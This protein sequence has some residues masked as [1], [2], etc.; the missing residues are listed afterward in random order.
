MWAWLERP[1]AFAAARDTF[2]LA[3][4]LTVAAY[5]LVPTAPPRLVPQLGL[6]DTL[7]A[8][9]GAG[10]AGASH[11]VQSPY[12]ALPS[13]HVVFALV[14]A[15]TVVSLARPAVVRV[16]AALYPALVVGV[17]GH[18]EPLPARRR[19]RHIRRRRERRRRAGGVAARG[20]QHA[21]SWPWG[22]RAVAS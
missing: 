7:T 20:A 18:G 22:R 14:A 9:W 2:V 21:R 11:V 19:R 16:L 15:G 3:Q 6:H 13:G 17:G 8:F 4:V 5:L 1:T 10:A 12:A